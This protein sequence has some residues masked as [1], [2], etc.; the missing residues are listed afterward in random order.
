MRYSWELD[1]TKPFGLVRMKL[2]PR[3]GLSA[4]A[5]FSAEGYPSLTMAYLTPSPLLSGMCA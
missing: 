5:N 4:S 1:L 3:W 2:P